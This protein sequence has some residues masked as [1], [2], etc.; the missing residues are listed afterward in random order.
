MAQK[1]A[2]E[3]VYL[4]I[5]EIKSNAN[6]ILRIESLQPLVKN[7]YIK[8]NRKHKTLLQQMKEFP[9]GKNDDG[10]DALKM[11]VDTAV[12]ARSC[13]E[14]GGYQTAEERSLQFEEGAY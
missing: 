11:A 10:P 9:M 8:F 3:G 13:C 7:R 1:S 12:L 5:E 6:K 4:P 14:T 2:K